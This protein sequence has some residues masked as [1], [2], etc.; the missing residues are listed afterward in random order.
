MNTSARTGVPVFA[1]ASARDAGFGGTGEKTLA[2]GQLAY[3]ED[4]NVVQYYDGSSWATLGP[5]TS[6]SVAIFREEQAQGTY[7]GGYTSGSFVTRTLNTTVLNNIAG[8]SL[9]SSEVTLPAGTYRM[10]AMLPGYGALGWAVGR[11]QNITDATTLFQGQNTFFTTGQGQ[12]V[13]IDTVITL[14]AQ[15]A[16][17][18]QFRAANTVATD[19]LGN[20]INTSG[21]TEVFST[22]IIER[23]A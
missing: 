8:C 7:G 4:L 18:F 3:L 17:A 22:V 16:V 21:I 14:A 6:P 13:P 20:R 12:M 11:I 23:T 10:T 1:D 15:K 9:A 5:S 19:G 2:E